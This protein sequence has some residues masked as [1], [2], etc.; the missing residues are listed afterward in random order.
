MEKYDSGWIHWCE[1]KRTIRVCEQYLSDLI[2]IIQEPEIKVYPYEIQV[3]YQLIQWLMLGSETRSGLAKKIQIRDEDYDFSDILKEIAILEAAHNMES[4]KY[5]LK[6]EFMAEFNPYFHKYSDEERSKAIESYTELEKARLKKDK[7]SFVSYLL[8]FLFCLVWFG[9][10]LCC[11]FYFMCARNKK[12]N[13]EKKY[14]KKM[15]DIDPDVMIPNWPVKTMNYCTKESLSLL[16]SQSMG[17]LWCCILYHVKIN[18][19]LR[20]SITLFQHCLRLLSLAAELLDSSEFKY[21]LKVQ[22]LLA[23]CLLF[24]SRLTTFFWNLCYKKKK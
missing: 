23:L 17:I 9:L 8:S 2:S 1:N 16:Q 11:V 15:M 12:A 21:D 5:R 19:K 13:C 22:Y 4:A 14:K 6:P 18:D 7:K 3:R 24:L 10:V 20:Y